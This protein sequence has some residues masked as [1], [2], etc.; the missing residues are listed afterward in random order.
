MTSNLIATFFVIALHYNS[1]KAI[2]ISEGYN[3][4]Y[5][6]QEFLTN[7]VARVAVPFFAMISGFFL[8]GKIR[9]VQ[10]Y[11]NALK[12][13]SRTLF[14]PYIVSSTLILLSM[15]VLNYVFS[16]KNRGQ[17][18]FFIIARCVFA[19]PLSVQFW[20]LRDLI[21]LTV[22]SPFIL[23][24]N[25]LY[26]YSF[27]SLLLLLWVQNIQPLPIIAGWYLINIDTLFFLLAGR[28]I[29]QI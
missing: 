3:W 22:I 11:I 9:D 1:K 5:V 7:G 15:I 25:R 29:I 28:G 20:F 13:K 14:V 16:P 27:G 4:N 12:N 17:I 23:N 21:F 26:S 6:L 8:F 2:D 24:N 10:S 19:Q 18:S